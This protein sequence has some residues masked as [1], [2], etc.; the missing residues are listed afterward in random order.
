MITIAQMIKP[1][2]QTVTAVMFVQHTPYSELAKRMRSKLDSLEKLGKFKIKLVERAGT[3]IVD[4]LH[5]SDAWNMMDCERDDCIICKTETSKKGSCRRRNV[6]YE[7][8]CIT[9]QKDKEEKE[10]LYGGEAEVE[11]ACK[12][13]RALCLP[14]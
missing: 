5:Q 13:A 4:M 3:K 8:F 10:R 11:G 2:V 7:T 9:C 12:D 14:G 6:L 1:W